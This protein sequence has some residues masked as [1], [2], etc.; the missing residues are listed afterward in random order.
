MRLLT[1]PRWRVAWP[2]FTKSNVVKD[3]VHCPGLPSS[4]DTLHPPAAGSAGGWQCSAESYPK[5]YPSPKTA[6]ITC[7]RWC[8]FLGSSPHPVAGQCWGH[9]GPT[10]LLQGGMTLMGLP[11]SRGPHG[12]GW[13]LLVTASQLNPSLC[14]KLLLL[15]VLNQKYWSILNRLPAHESLPQSLLLGERDLKQAGRWEE[16]WLVTG[17]WGDQHACQV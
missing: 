3:G 14:P 17:C 7:S 11:I 6:P 13:P 1:L 2:P 4:T 5:H 12:I 16:K 9:G 10:P 15:K 8:S